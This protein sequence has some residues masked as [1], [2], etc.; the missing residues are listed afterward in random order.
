MVI[1]MMEAIPITMSDGFGFLIN[2]SDISGKK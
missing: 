2:N 1:K